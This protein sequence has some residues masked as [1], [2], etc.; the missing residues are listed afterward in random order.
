M[1]LQ[2]NIHDAKSRLS[3]LLAQVEAGD[4][5]IIARANKPIARLVAYNSPKTVRQLG[6]A[7]G[8]LQMEP[9]FDTLPDD[10]MA[11]FS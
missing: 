10:F 9:D 7:K 6:E 5:V 2:V 11:H 4:E 1:S 3:I 8:Q